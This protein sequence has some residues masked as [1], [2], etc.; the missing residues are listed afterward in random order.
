MEKKYFLLGSS[1]TSL[2]VKIIR[3][4]FGLACLTIAVF[5]LIYN[6]N[7]IKSD[8]MLWITIVFLSGFGFYQIWAGFGKA[9]RFIEVGDCS[10][11]LK[12]N[13]ILPAAVMN[14]QDIESIR[15]YPLNFIFLLKSGKKILLRLGT[16]YNEIN[17]D[18][19]DA[20][21]SFADANDIPLDI[22]QESI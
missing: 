22:V 18:I 7:S 14:S 19:K 21:I 3:V 1:D 2:M 9:T 15:L 11:T 10:I 12:K 20:V 17:A 6:I 13:A 16:T 5:W 8:R 4:L